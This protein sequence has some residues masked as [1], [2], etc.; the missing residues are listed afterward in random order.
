MTD[1]V[2]RPASDGD[3]P[4]DDAVR[5]ESSLP[6]DKL[7]FGVAASMIVLFVAMGPC[8]RRRSRARRPRRWGG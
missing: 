1:L 2:R 5:D 8:G 3:P 7:V 4:G 6:V